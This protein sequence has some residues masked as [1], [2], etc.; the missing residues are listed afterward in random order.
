MHKTTNRMAI[1]NSCNRIQLSLQKKLLCNPTYHFIP[2]NAVSKK[3]PLSKIWTPQNPIFETE[4]IYVRF[5]RGCVYNRD[6][7]EARFRSQEPERYKACISDSMQDCRLPC[8]SLSCRFPYMKTY[9]TETHGL[10]WAQT[11]VSPLPNHFW[12]YGVH[13]QWD[14]AMFTP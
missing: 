5:S 7:N 9:Y 14:T 1:T 4:R 10:N 2:R 3:V 11:T 13:T 8:S 6:F 12:M